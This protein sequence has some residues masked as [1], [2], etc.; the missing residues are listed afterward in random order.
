MRRLITE[1]VSVYI[2]SKLHGCIIHSWEKY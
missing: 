2:L 1:R